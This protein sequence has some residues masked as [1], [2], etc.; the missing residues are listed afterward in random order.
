MPET[1]EYPWGAIVNTKGRNKWLKE[2]NLS[3]RYKEIIK[4]YKETCSS[5]DENGRNHYA[6]QKI[7]EEYDPKWAEHSG[8]G[9]Y[10]LHEERDELT[11]EAKQ[12][13]TGLTM[14]KVNWILANVHGETVSRADAPCGIS[15][16]VM[17]SARTQ[18]SL[19]QKL[20]SM[21]AEHAAGGDMESLDADML[22]KT[23]LADILREEF[24]DWEKA[25]AKLR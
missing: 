8:N 1:F 19:M 13:L 11:E 24:A 3:E 9:A 6:T 23:G 22:N 21:S 20:V 2:R 12:S 7:L 5:M 14:D 18:P 16:G 25:I 17:V 10:V 4:G 15:Y